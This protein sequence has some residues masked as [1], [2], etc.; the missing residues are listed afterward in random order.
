M[1]D[2]EIIKPSEYEKLAVVPGEDTLTLL[3]CTPFLIGT[4]RLLINAV[5]I[6]APEES[7]EGVEFT[8][9]NEAPVIKASQNPSKSVVL[10]KYAL[11]GIVGILWITLL[12][13]VIRF[14]RTFR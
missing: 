11:M 9:V 3:T 13:V 1:Y 14:F 5:R 7:A 2:S 6:N 10:E 12:A 4:E 8:P